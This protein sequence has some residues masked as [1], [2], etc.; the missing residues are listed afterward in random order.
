MPGYATRPLW[1]RIAWMVAIW[2]ASVLGLG[3]ISIVIRLWLHA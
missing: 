1:Q 3:V 2:L